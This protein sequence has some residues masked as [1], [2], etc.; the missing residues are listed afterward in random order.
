MPR[1]AGLCSL[2]SETKARFLSGLRS[3]GQKLLKSIGVVARPEQPGQTEFLLCGPEDRRN[4]GN[5]KTVSQSREHFQEDGVVCAEGVSVTA[6]KEGRR[7]QQ[8][9]CQSMTAF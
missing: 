2:A 9:T 5:K 1:G 8:G 4:Q 6:T 3:K 7:G